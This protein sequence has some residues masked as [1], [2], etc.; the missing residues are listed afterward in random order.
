MITHLNPC[1]VKPLHEARQQ[2]LL[3]ELMADMLENGWQGRPLL[4]IERG[5]D[6]LAWTGSHRIAA[7][8]Q[9]GLSTVPC[10][11]L[12]QRKLSRLGFDSESGHVMDYERLNILKRLG[13]ETALHIMWEEGRK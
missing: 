13:D 9:A 3:N 2:R 6:Y 12:D 5:A 8:R 4:V 1:D 11:V 10:Y 7:A